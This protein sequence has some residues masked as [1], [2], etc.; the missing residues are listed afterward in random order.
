MKL[1]GLNKTVT[2]IS[3]SVLISIW[4]YTYYQNIYP[5]FIYQQNYNT[6]NITKL[7]RDNATLKHFLTVKGYYSS[8]NQWKSNQ[9][10]PSD[11]GSPPFPRPQPLA[12][13]MWCLP[14]IKELH[15]MP[16]PEHGEERTVTHQLTREK[17]TSMVYRATELLYGIHER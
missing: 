10:E 11:L 7:Q 5:K 8:N 16:V 15:V 14:F 4:I 9:A 1:L 2:F 3:L 17:K 12:V 13:P 6:K